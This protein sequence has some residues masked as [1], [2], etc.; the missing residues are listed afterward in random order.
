MSPSSSSISSAVFGRRSTTFT[1]TKYLTENLLNTLS[2]VGVR[3]L[4]QQPRR[5]K[6][7]FTFSF[8]VNPSQTSK[9]LRTRTLYGTLYSGCVR[10]AYSSRCSSSILT[11]KIYSTHTHVMALNQ[12]SI[13]SC[14]ILNCVQ[15]K[16]IYS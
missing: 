1:L 7:N 9:S 10:A 2:F 16:C 11:E 8:R 3:Y 4:L 15:L 14:S 12:P 6:R 5:G 13:Q